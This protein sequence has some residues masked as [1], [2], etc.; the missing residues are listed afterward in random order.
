MEKGL[1]CALFASVSFAGS[2]VLVRKATAL[3]EESFTAMATSVFIGLPFFAVVL[4]ISGE[5]HQLISVSGN[6]LIRLSIA[7]MAH[8]ILGRLLSYNAYRLIGAN[9]ATP[10]VSINPFY[11]LI[12]SVLFLDETFTIFLI[13]GIFC[14]SAG[15]TLISA[16]KSSV[17]DNINDGFF[18]NRV[19][20]IL[21]A[22]GGGVIWGSTPVL[23]K[24]AILEI[25]SPFASV[26]I[27][28]IAATI[29]MSFVLL[30]RRNREQL[31]QLPTHKAVVPVIFG[32]I[33]TSFGQLFSFIALA[34][35]P[36]NLV[37]PIINTQMLIVFVLSFFI[38]R[39]IEVFTSKVILGALA[40]LA[41]TYLIL[42]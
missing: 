2:T 16:E 35:I 11:T 14:V 31:S 38:N 9:K 20:G 10:I 6:A 22:L 18:S 27:S 37:S 29:A 25:G 15:A 12:L 3:T 36:A 39:H 26:F 13:L 5:W 33:M 7:G 19:K 41:G 34:N 1:I 40:T 28:Y 24:P 42:H 4:F 21:Y 30:R 17:N 8:Y 23:L 32:G